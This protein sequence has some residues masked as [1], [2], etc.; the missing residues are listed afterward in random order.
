MKEIYISKLSEY[1]DAIERLKSYYPSHFLLHNPTSILF[2]YR[3]LSKQS[4][5][6]L[7]GLFRKQND[8]I[9]PD[10]D[11]T[12][13][14]DK[15]LAFGQ[16]KD[17]LKS[18][19][20]EASNILSIPSGELGRWAEYAQHYGVPTRFLDWSRNPLVAL[21]FACRDQQREDGIVWLLH[22]RNYERIPIANSIST[23]GKQRRE[24]IT[25]I[26]NGSTEYELP[27]LY[28]PYYVDSRMSAQRSYFM[29]WGSKRESFE[30]MFCDEK[31]CMVLPENETGGRTYGIHEQEALLFRFLIHAD[32]KQPLLRELD[33]VGINEKSLFPGLDG[34][35][36]YVERTYRFDYNEAISA[37][38]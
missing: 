12:V 24:I 1:L 16:E 5:K 10:N 30:K 14:N 27:L 18:F 33:T 11:E 17:I 37:Y 9:D 7:P 6:L 8:I 21:Y 31:N 38:D 29:V 22:A 3:G 35:G 13:E 34:I 26:I 25:E 2:L 36:R 4:Y 28:T 23:I 20:H 15:Y 32:R 19:I